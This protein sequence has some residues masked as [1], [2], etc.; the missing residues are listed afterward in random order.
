[1]I[2]L[3]SSTRAGDIKS[4]QVC[5]L[6]LSNV[7]IYVQFVKKRLKLGLDYFLEQVRYPTFEVVLFSRESTIVNSTLRNLNLK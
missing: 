6:S 5:D 2:V 1:M 4:V 7:S 3:L